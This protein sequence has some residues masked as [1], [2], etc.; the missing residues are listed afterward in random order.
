MY[1]YFFSTPFQFSSR[2]LLR[3][4]KKK[5]LSKEITIQF[6]GFLLFSSQRS[7]KVVKT[8][9]FIDTFINFKSIGQFIFWNRV[10]LFLFI[11]LVMRKMDAG[12][13]LSSRC[14]GNVFLIGRAFALL[15]FSSLPNPMLL[16]NVK[17]DTNLM[18]FKIKVILS[19]F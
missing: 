1:A 7:S 10:I 14:L 18:T 13:L 3:I 6:G 4:G 2:F 8:H 12:L 19:N 11:P 17:F 15:S 5:Q 9:L 16:Y